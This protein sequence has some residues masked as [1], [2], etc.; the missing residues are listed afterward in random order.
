MSLE[1]LRSVALFAKE[2]LE[3]MLLNKSSLIPHFSKGEGE[4]LPVA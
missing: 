4:H 1:R 3:E 2:R